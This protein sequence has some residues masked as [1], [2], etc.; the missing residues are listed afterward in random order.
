MVAAD[1]AFTALMLPGRRVVLI[2]C[3]KGSTRA[4]DHDQR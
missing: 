2:G 3:A 1:V 4:G